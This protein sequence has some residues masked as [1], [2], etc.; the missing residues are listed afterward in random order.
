MDL[1]DACLNDLRSGEMGEAF[2]CSRT[3]DW[4][5]VPPLTKEQCLHAYKGLVLIE[6]EDG[7]EE[8]VSASKW[9]GSLCRN[10]ACPRPTGIL[11]SELVD[12]LFA[13]NCFLYRCRF[14]GRVT[15]HPEKELSL[16]PRAG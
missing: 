13:D 7:G 8:L 14:R 1:C 10:G 12:F 6:T 11:S 15:V 5:N 2:V 9:L 3:H 16:L 4:Y